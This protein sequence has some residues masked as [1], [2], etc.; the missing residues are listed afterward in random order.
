M[1][2]DRWN[3]RKRLYETIILKN[4]YFNYKHEA[5]NLLLFKE[6]SIIAN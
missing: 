5:I 3:D 4:D 2:Y 6:I 1:I